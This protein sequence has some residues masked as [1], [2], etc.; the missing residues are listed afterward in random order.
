MSKICNKKILFHKILRKLQVF[1]NKDIPI[2]IYYQIVFQIL[3]R[4]IIISLTSIFIN[5]NY[6]T[7][8]YIHNKI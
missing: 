3:F 4:H 2:C 8:N 5:I 1:M 6:I 7:F